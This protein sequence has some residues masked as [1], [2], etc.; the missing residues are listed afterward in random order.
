MMSN[1]KYMRFAQGTLRRMR[2]YIQDPQMKRDVND[3]LNDLRRADFIYEKMIE[4]AKMIGVR[5]PAFDGD[6]IGYPEDD[7]KK[8]DD[9]TDEN[10]QQKKDDQ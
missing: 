2:G 1:N 8:D 9:S 7:L 6:M 10:D 4:D 3:V 5:N